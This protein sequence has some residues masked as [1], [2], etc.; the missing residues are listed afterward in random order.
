METKWY[1]IKV[2]PGKERTL[3]EQFNEYINLGRIKNIKRFICP[4]E[5]EY[6]I[7]RKK[8]VLREK[9]I[10]NG[11]LYFETE[12]ILQ[13]DDLKEISSLPNIMGLM[14]D[15]KPMMLSSQDVKKI[16]KDEILE[17]YTASKSL[18]YLLGEKVLV[19]DGP[20][21]N[22]NGVIRNVKDDKV[23]VEIKIFGRGNIVSLNLDQI[24]KYY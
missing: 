4:T 18:Q 9:V 16:I 11:Y 15:K 13:E 17:N 24:K 12:N 5:K 7:V 8:R 10:Y 14:G 6:I 20:F 1:I 23:E 19:C 3:N 22:F 2:M 21:Q